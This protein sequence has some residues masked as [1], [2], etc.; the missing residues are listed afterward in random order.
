MA[1]AARQSPRAGHL[2][3]CLESTMDPH[4]NCAGLSRIAQGGIHIH[5][6]NLSPGRNLAIQTVAAHSPGLTSTAFAHTV[7][8]GKE[9]GCAFRPGHR[10]SAAFGRRG[11]RG[12]LGTS[13]AAEFKRCHL[14]QLHT[15]LDS[16][17]RAMPWGWRFLADRLRL[18]LLMLS[19]TKRNRWIQ[20]Q[21]GIQVEQ[22]A[23]V[24]RL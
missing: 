14:Y 11:A 2:P 4:R 20:A 22:F 18:R 3:G 8:Q 6:A 16:G 12:R 10:F 15:I 13:A 23:P 5:A 21:I 9:S 24:Q 7:L 1:I 17:E 19:Y